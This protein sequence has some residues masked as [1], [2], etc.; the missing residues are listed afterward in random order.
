MDTRKVPEEQKKPK[1]KGRKKVSP[2]PQTHYQGRAIILPS[3]QY[4][5]SKYLEG[6]EIRKTTAAIL[7]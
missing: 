1:E 4:F 7:L 2:V 5:A 6:K 3:K